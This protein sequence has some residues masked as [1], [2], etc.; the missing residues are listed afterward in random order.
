MDFRRNAT[1]YDLAQL[2][3]MKSLPEFEKG[4]D[5]LNRYDRG[6]AEVTDPDS[7]LGYYPLREIF[8]YVH[9]SSPFHMRTTEDRGHLSV[10]GP[11]PVIKD[12]PSSP[13]EIIR[14][15]KVALGAY[16]IKLAFDHPKGVG[17][18]IITNEQEW[19]QFE[20]TFSWEGIYCVSAVFVRY[21]DPVG[22]MLDIGDES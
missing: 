19:A 7:Y 16:H 3:H 6:E 9:A 8:Y 11:A 1:P 2:E 15:L 20:S 14:Y 10:I 12:V 5:F 22:V 18:A 13:L 17:W 4:C 21:G